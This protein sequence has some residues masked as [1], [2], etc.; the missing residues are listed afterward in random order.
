MASR[1]GFTC[2]ILCVT[3]LTIFCTISGGIVPLHAERGHGYERDRFY[4]P[5]WEL[6]GRHGHNH[7]YPARGY[8][9]PALP[10]GYLDL[11]FGGGHYFFRSGAWYRAQGPAFVVVRPPVGIRLGILPPSYSTIVIGGVPYYYA[12]GIYYS[13]VPNT[14][15]YAVVDPP[16]G[17]ETAIPQPAPAQA[18]T[19]PPP[20]AASPQPAPAVSLPQSLFVY[21]RQGQSKNEIAADRSECTGWATEQTGSD[22]AH[23]RAGGASRAGDFQR[24]VKTC[25]E[26]RGYTVE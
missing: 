15:E 5:H 18:Q 12:N 4:S 11:T 23:P 22:P 21:P 10:P 26:G 7:Y 3:L 16:P 20:A 24:A 8:V 14:S 19:L 9:L 25:L 17:Y 6:D 2:P 13:A 1:R